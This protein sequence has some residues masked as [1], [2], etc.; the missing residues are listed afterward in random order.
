MFWEFRNT[1]LVGFIQGEKYRF[2]SFST[3]MM[4]VIKEVGYIQNT[5]QCREPVIQMPVLF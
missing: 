2:M 3:A 1:Y 4:R 5:H